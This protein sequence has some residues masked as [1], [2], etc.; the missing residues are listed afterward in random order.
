M[1]GPRELDFRAR[2]H[3][4]SV[5]AADYWAAIDLVLKRF[6]RPPAPCFCGVGSGV[7]PEDLH[8][9]DALVFGSFFTRQSTQQAWIEAQRLP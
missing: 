1:A 2:G 9:A 5:G 4:N 8:T 7:F 3:H 6:D